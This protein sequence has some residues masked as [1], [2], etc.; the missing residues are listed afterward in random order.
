MRAATSKRWLLIVAALWAAGYARAAD[1]CTDNDG[2]GHVS[3]IGCLSATDC[4]DF[5]PWINPAASESCNGFDDDCDGSLDEVCV[6]ACVNPERRSRVTSL[7]PLP[8]GSQYQPTLA[9][10]RRRS[11]IARAHWDSTYCWRRVVTV[12]DE[13]GNET[14]PPIPLDFFA[15]PSGGVREMFATWAGDRFI[16]AWTDADATPGTCE[17]VAPY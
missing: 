12:I 1:P 9:H 17:Y 2:D 4:N 3:G 11:L 7:T 15:P 6:T 14:T 8:G 13:A 5:D 16:V 10:G